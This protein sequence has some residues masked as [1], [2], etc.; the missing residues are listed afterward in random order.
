MGGAVLNNSFYVIGGRSMASSAFA[1]TTDNQKL[2]CLNTPTNI[3]TNAGSMIVSAGGNGAL[4]PG[5]TVT[6][7][8]K[9]QNSG[10]PGV[11][12]TTPALTGTLQ[13]TGGVTN[14]SGPATYGAV[15]S[16]PTPTGQNFTFTV[17]PMLACGATVTCTLHMQD[18]ATDYGNLTYTFVTGTSAVAFSQ[19]WDAVAAPALPAGWTTTATGVGVPWVTSTSTPNSA[20]NEAFSPDGSNVGDSQLISPS[21]AVPAGGAT[22]TFKNSFNTESTYDGE[23]LEISINGGAF[24]DIIT[25]G[26]T[27]VAGGYTGPISTS[28]M[29]P[30]AGRQAWNGNSGGYI[31]STVTLPPAANGQMVNLKWR[32][33]SDNSVAVVGVMI[34][35]ISIS[36]PV[37][38]SANSIVSAASRLTHGGAGDFS[39]NLPLTGTAG[40]ECRSS[41]TYLI[42]LTFSSGPVTMGTASVTA[43]TGTAGSPTFS[44]NTMTVPLTGVANAQTLTLTYSNVSAAADM[45]MGSVNIGFLIGDTGGNG[46]VNSADVGQTKAQSGNAVTASNFREDLNH[47][48]NVNASDV[49][50]VKSK[51]GTAIP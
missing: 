50:L 27:F 12:C 23:V 16:P 7:T 29:S 34:D 44:G 41:A 40:V 3:I 33:A 13:A 9:V 28:F 37:C 45:T 10:G 4:D 17:D 43:G 39:V 21:F 8:L 24:A 5:E 26:G 32:M 30:I 14:P 2:T 47:D 51:T 36:N 46:S 6:V 25:A 42:D 11:V 49:G 22:L 48:G 20:P 19:N 15:C 18:G 38:D 35:D 1:G 31:T